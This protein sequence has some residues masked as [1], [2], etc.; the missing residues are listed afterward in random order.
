M[1]DVQLKVSRLETGCHLFRNEVAD[2][3]KSAAQAIKA[4]EAKT[5]AVVKEAL[6][7]T[8][9]GEVMDTRVAS[10]EQRINGTLDIIS[11]RM[12]TLEASVQIL[13]AEERE[14]GS[15]S[16]HTEH[17][18][19][20]LGPE[21]LTLKE[22]L[23]QVFI[24]MDELKLG[25]DDLASQL[26]SQKAAA[27]ATKPIPM[28]LRDELLAM[29]LYMQDRFET[30]A[31]VIASLQ[32]ENSLLKK[33][34]AAVHQ[35]AGNALWEREQQSHS[36]QDIQLQLQQQ[37]FQRQQQ[38]EIQK[39]Q[40][41]QRQQ[42]LEIQQYEFQQQQAEI[43]KQFNSQQQANLQKP[44]FPSQPMV[45]QGTMFEPL[46][47]LFA[48]QGS[49]GVASSPV[50]PIPVHESPQATVLPFPP[51]PVEEGLN[52]G[53][54]TGN[55]PADDSQPRT[56]R[57]HHVPEPQQL[58]QARGPQTAVPQAFEHSY[59]YPTAT[60]YPTHVQPS[61]YAKPQETVTVSPAGKGEEPLPTS[62]NSADVGVQ[63]EPCQGIAPP[64]VP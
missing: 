22:A 57:P 53:L 39:Q 55:W 25:H 50:R 18:I 12:S 8:H 61:T 59:G 5:V 26:Y 43:L 10:V 38:V 56:Y 28:E 13:Q 37:E 24:N 62:G 36:L 4:G 14:L 19:T 54:G 60:G 2:Q 44:V 32:E 35:G 11:C 33:E 20:V 9:V 27:S 63:S 51:K 31:R 46:P 48:Q 58:N 42:Q 34:M 6:A 47:D 3:L 23:K 49:S 45:Q 15:Q 17:G 16:R 7:E 40:E 30:Q 29:K 52:V 41:F 64:D 1:A 21:I